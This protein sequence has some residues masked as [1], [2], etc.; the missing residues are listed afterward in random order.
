MNISCIGSSYVGLVT[1]SCFA[2]LGH[3]VICCDID[4]AKI[5]NLQQGKIPFY[6]PGLK[7]VVDRT[8]QKGKLAFTTNIKEAIEKSDVIFNCVGTP[9]KEDGSAD[10][11]FVFSVAQSVAMHAQGY[12]VLINK[13]TVPPGTATKTQDFIREKN[14]S[15]KVDVVSNP[16]FLKEGN[17]VHD[18]T[19]PDKI[20]VGAQSSKAFA[21]LREV[22][23]GF[24]RPYMDILETDWMTAEIMKYANNAFLAT[25]IS[26]IN[27]I[28]N[29]CDQVGGDIKTVAR[30]LGMDY[31][32]NPK[33]LNA[34]VGYG[35]SCFPKDIRAL[36]AVAK[37]KGYAAQLLQEVHSLNERQK[38]I[39][40]HKIEKEFGQD[41]TGHIFTLWGLSFKPKTNDIREAPSLVLINLLKLRGAQVIVYDPV[42]MEDV[43]S[44]YRDAL[45]YASSLTS[46]TKNSSAI[47]LLTEWDEF[48]NF[49]LKD[50]LQDM[51]HKV[52]FDGRNIYEPEQVRKAGFK[53]YGIGR[54]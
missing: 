42:A 3:H 50:L 45:T 15:S 49:N 14:P 52:I 11:Q 12:K 41:L 36:I 5:K 26:F 43:K 37:E 6:E 28:A 27:E 1:G 18:F 39:I 33:F 20:V 31:R 19:H 23:S 30:G 29:I 51:K 47:I 2:D 54:Q 40:L 7:D 16:E 35:G 32:I 25:K 17:A 8:S 9:S 48:R 21:V 10:L 44:L 24:V 22:Y 53:Y 4:E 34:G 38:K 13:S 46:S